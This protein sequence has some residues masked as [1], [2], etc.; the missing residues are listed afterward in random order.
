LL[1]T[2]FLKPDEEIVIYNTGTGLKYLESWA[3]AF[4][5]EQITQ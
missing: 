3:S 5:G 1:V 2:C 4:L